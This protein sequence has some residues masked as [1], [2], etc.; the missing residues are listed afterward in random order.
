V[1]FYNDDDTPCSSAGS[2]L[3]RQSVAFKPDHSFSLVKWVFIRWNQLLLDRQ[4]RTG[5][6]HYSRTLISGYEK[7]AFRRPFRTKAV[8]GSRFEVFPDRLVSLVH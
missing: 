8:G 5:G 6:S 2:Y 1:N 7:K 3:G 4:R